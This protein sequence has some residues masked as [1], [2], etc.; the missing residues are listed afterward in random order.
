MSFPHKNIVNLYI[1]FEL[2]AKSR[3]LNTDFTL[4]NCLFGAVKLTKNT[5]LDK[6]GYSGYGIGFDARS[7]LDG[8]LGKNV[9][10]LGVDMKPSEHV[11]N[12]NKDTLN[13]GE[14][15]KHG[16]DDIRITA[17]AKY[18]INF[19]QAGKKLCQVCIIM[20]AIFSYMFMQ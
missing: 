2:D 19:K 15:P 9:I 12:K 10:I 5:D 7:W 18:L 17:E 3:D 4:G 20:E 13:L 11:D 16:L 6:Y 14:V 8:S 1:T